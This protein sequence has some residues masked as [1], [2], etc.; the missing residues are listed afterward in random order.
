MQHIHIMYHIQ[1]MY[2]M[3]H[4]LYVHEWPDNYTW[5]VWTSPKHTSTQA[6]KHTNANTTVNL[7]KFLTYLCCF[8]V[9]LDKRVPFFTT[10]LF[11][12][13]TVVACMF[14]A[15]MLCVWH[16]IVC[17]DVLFVLVI[18]I[19]LSMHTYILHATAKMNNDYQILWIKE[20]LPPELQ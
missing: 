7:V 10:G 4:I 1:H 9:L 14:V 12:L 2:H 20:E 16:D 17:F 15:T 13:C 8:F 18:I 6:H 5:R 19:I 3:Q 11:S